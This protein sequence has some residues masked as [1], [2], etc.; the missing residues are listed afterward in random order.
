[1]KEIDAILICGQCHSVFD[2]RDMLAP[3]PKCGGSISHGMTA[4]GFLD[5]LD[6]SQGMDVLMRTTIANRICDVLYEEG[7]KYD[8]ALCYPKRL[9]KVE[10]GE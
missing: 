9:M 8:P 2:G 7:W 3:C 10:E 6:D 5:H 1:M 4:Q